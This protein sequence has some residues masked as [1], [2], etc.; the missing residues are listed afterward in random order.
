[1]QADLVLNHIG[2]L[3]TTE[4]YSNHPQTGQ[5]LGQLRVY[6]DAFLAVQSDRILAL[7]QSVDAAQYIGPLTRV[8]DMAGCT[9]LP[10]FVDP[11]THLIF[12]GWR[13]KELAMKLAG[14]SY[15]EILAA[16]YGI[17]STMRNT[18]EASLDQLVKLGQQSLD[19]MLL[20]GTTTAEAKSGYG[21]T[22]V[23]ELKQ[24]RAAAI[25]HER[26]PVDVVSTFLGAHAVPPEYQ[27]R[28]GAY[29]D[30]IVDEMLPAVAAEGLASFC[31]VFCEA[32]VFSVA[33]SRRILEAGLAR[34]L[35]AKLHAD[36]LVTLGGA[37][38]A[39]ELGAVSADHL[40][41]A[42]EAGIAAMAKAGVVA[43]LLP[44]TS[45]TLRSS[46]RPNVASMLAAGVPIALATD[47]NPGTCP[48]ESMQ[49]VLTLAWQSLGLSPAQAVAA[50]TINSAHALGL[51]GQVGSL[52]PG[53]LADF[54]VFDAPNFDFVA[55]HFG[56]NL[57][58]QV[59]KS[60]RQVVR[61]GAL[62][63]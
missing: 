58:Q 11:H 39:A 52:E 33:E 40:L 49:F 41:F 18:R 55:Y 36:E 22:T 63:Y 28:T 3:A 38:L 45:F 20:S 57:V 56:V 12:A 29:V 34:G 23:S 51:A 30:L 50:A 10:G 5:E 9:V 44:G 17:Q 62:C 48:N 60:G 26:H 47:F 25:L 1:M 21:L 35:R 59:W 24:L 43:V 42:S 6:E 46:Q 61:D 19:R 14:Q 4:G 27:G 2:Q 53:K 8:L 32:G 13:E 15:L 16:G 7:G 37:E 54:S 31:D